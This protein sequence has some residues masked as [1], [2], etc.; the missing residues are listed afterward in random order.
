M[1]QRL[2]YQVM[3]TIPL[4]R[5]ADNKICRGI[6]MRLKPSLFLVIMCKVRRKGEWLDCRSCCPVPTGQPRALC[7]SSYV[8]TLGLFVFAISG[9]NI[10]EEASNGIP[11]RDVGRIEIKF[12]PRVFPTPVRE[13]QTHLEEEVN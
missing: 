4:G 13:S 8:S 9:K 11:T 5:L 3:P 6:A 12:T 2:K 10:F 7:V 1:T